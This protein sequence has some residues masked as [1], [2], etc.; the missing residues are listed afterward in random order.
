MLKNIFQLAQAARYLLEYSGEKY[1]FKS[2]DREGKAN[3]WGNK[4]AI[5]LTSVFAAWAKEKGAL[6][7]PF[8]NAS[9]T[10][11]DDFRVAL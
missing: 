5:Y 3:E 7:L 1:E 2:P 9:R 10:G 8:P 11:R 4:L 6:G